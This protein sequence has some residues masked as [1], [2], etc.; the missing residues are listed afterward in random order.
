MVKMNESLRRLIVDRT[1]ANILRQEAI[2]HGMRPIRHDGWSK[3]KAGITTIDEV[4]RVTMEDEF[5]DY[6]DT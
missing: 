1:A 6:G 3:I 2:R 4:L 5:I